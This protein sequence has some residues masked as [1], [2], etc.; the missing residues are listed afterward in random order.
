MATVFSR[1]RCLS[2]RLNH[3][4]GAI[5]VDNAPETSAFK[6]GDWQEEEM[7]DVL[8]RDFGVNATAKLNNNDYCLIY[9]SMLSSLVE[10][11]WRS[12][13]VAFAALISAHLDENG[14]GY[15]AY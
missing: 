5:T 13:I 4:S 12:R 15:D 1:K 10:R 8:A 7:S 9:S 11:L 2:S 6:I 3:A 14:E